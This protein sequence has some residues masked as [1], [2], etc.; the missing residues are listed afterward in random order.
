MKP[1]LL[2]LTL[3]ILSLSALAETH[4]KRFATNQQ[5]WSANAYMLI[6]DQG[7]VLIDSL[8]RR[9][10]ARNFA[11][12]IK[13]QNKPVLGLI[14]THAHGDHYSG[15]A[16]LKRILGDFPVMATPA[17]A[18]TLAS[19]FELFK[20]QTAPQ[21]APDI[22][23]ASAPE[24]DQLIDVTK[25]LVLADISLQVRDLGEGESANATIVFHAQSGA[26]FAGDILM[27]HHHY[28]VGQGNT[29]NILKQFEQ[30][31]QDYQGKVSMVYGGHGDP[32]PL[33]L[34]KQQSEYV[35]TLTEV[36]EKMVEPASLKHGKPTPEAMTQAVETILTAYPY[37][38]DYGYP[39]GTIARMNLS[40]LF[41][42]HHSSS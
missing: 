6:G 42:R 4:I 33:H 29:D 18:A 7:I 23:V 19:D 3:L 30:L 32:S 16:D 1:L 38:N 36:Y 11:A 15:I 39:R 20:T 35:R 31:Q 10:D 26:L 28:Y 2:T 22:W 8:L 41:R 27:A 17:T 34:L 24:V 21:F 37:L 40:Q 25:P 14:L 5:D 9:S 12:M 13:A